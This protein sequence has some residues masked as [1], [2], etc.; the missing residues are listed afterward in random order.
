MDVEPFA[1]LTPAAA[2][3]HSDWVL[4]S[5]VAPHPFLVTVGFRVPTK[6]VNSMTASSTGWCLSCGERHAHLS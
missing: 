2:S 4:K 5:L 1:G 6:K 3:T